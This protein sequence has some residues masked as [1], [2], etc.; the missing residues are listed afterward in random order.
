[1]RPRWD[2]SVRFQTRLRFKVVCP[3]PHYRRIESNVSDRTKI[4]R[5][6]G[7]CQSLRWLDLKDNG[8]ERRNPMCIL[9]RWTMRR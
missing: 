2:T 9:S 5:I 6:V 3:E 8:G 4:F 7:P 1:M